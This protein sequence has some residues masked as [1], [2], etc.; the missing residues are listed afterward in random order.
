MPP[1]K[2]LPQPHPAVVN[3]H[4]AHL[5]TATMSTEVLE[6]AELHRDQGTDLKYEAMVKPCAD[7]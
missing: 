6:K 1:L 3:S 7:D 5:P 4:K 2:P